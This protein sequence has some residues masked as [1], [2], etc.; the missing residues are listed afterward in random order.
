MVFFMD[1]AE[2]SAQLSALLVESVKAC[3]PS[4]ESLLARLYLISDILYNSTLTSISRNYWTYKKYLELLLPKV[5]EDLSRC[6]ERMGRDEGD[7]FLGDIARMVEVRS[8]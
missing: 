7:R 2:N 3:R 5:I 8:E 6:V 1:N 4:R